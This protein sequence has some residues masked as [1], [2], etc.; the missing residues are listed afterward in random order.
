MSSDFQPFSAS[1][2]G[3]FAQLLSELGCS[4]ALSTYKAGKLILL[5][6]VN[7]QVT[8]LPRSF[9][10]PMGMALSGRQMAVAT[11]EEVI[12][13]ANSPALGEGY[14]KAPGRYDSLWMPRA[15]YFNGE[16]DTH[17]MA[18]GADGLWAVNTRFSCLALV[19]DTFS[20]KPMWQP[21]F[22]TDLLP[23][24]RCHLN[25]MAMLD[26]KPKYVTLLGKSD[27]PKG[28]R[29]HKNGGG[30]LMDV[31]RNEVVTGGLS[32]PHSPRI[33][34]GQLYVCNSGEG[35][36]L[37]IDQESGAATTLAKLPGFLRGLSSVG[38]YLVVGMSLLR[39][40]RSFGGLPIEATDEALMCGVSFVHKHTGEI[41]GSFRY[42]STVEEL[43]DVHVLEH[44]RRPGILG[45]GDETHRNALALPDRGYWAT[46]EQQPVN[47]PPQQTGGWT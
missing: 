30:L 17:D 25:G 33:I 15:V 36:I 26:G 27:T 40:T 39:D 37:A 28:W 18:W 13:L 41:A 7:G 24:D 23:E 29:P 14:P 3:R 16:T 20:F 10:K 31:T 42:L 2:S 12:V 43:Y 4:L 8:Q 45:T 32:M 5:S 38:D 46:S 6:M 11:R 22:I 47:T 34:D 21:P 44:Q 19:G 1:I 9:N 35:E